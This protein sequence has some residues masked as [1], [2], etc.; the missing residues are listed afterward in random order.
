[1]LTHDRSEVVKVLQKAAESLDFSKTSDKDNAEAQKEIQQNIK[2]LIDFA[3]K[4]QLN[5]NH[6][7]VRKQIAHINKKVLVA[8][9][10]KM[11]GQLGDVLKSSMSVHSNLVNEL[12]KIQDIINEEKLKSKNSSEL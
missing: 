1:M 5:S 7:N 12:F 8:S 2:D 3:E 10:D 11:V 9:A 6:P 4:N